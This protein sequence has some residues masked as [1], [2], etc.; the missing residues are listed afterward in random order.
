M[1]AE[2]AYILLKGTISIKWVAAPVEEDNDGKELVFNN[3][4][5]MSEINNTQ[6]DNAKHTDVIIPLYI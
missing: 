5:F 3:Y 1:I 4:W 6:I 2:N